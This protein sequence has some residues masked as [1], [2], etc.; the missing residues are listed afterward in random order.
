MQSASPVAPPRAIY[1]AAKAGKEV[2]LSKSIALAMAA[3]AAGLKPWG[4][5]EEGTDG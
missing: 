1:R 3:V 5:K 4:E 2:P